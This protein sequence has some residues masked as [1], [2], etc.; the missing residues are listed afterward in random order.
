MAIFCASNYNCQSIL[1]LFL[2][3]VSNSDI[4]THTRLSLKQNQGRK[5]AA[6]WTH[7]KNTKWRAPLY[8]FSTSPRRVLAALSH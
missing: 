2:D 5:G 7:T 1:N 8:G 6:V 4:D 3:Q